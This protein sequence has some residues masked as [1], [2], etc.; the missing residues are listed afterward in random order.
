M[1]D[2]KKLNKKELVEL[3]IKSDN[4]YYN[5]GKPIFDDNE[6]DEIKDYLKLIDKKNDYFKRI[7]ADIPDDNKVKLPFF[8][9]SQDK[10]KDDDKTLQK[11]INKYNSPSSYIISEKLDGISCLIVY[12]NINSIFIYTRGNGIYGQNISHLKKI[13]SGIP[14]NIKDK[15]A[16]RGELIINKNN[17]GKISHKGANARNIVAGFVNSKNIDVEIA[18][19][20]EFVAY[21][22]LEPRTNIETALITA[23]KY[24]FNVVKNIKLDYL[25][26]SNLYELYKKWKEMSKYEIDGLV[27][28]HNIIYKLKSGENPKYS[29]AFKSLRMQEQIIVIVTDIEWNVSKDKYLKPIVKFNEIKLNGVKIK[30]ATGFNADYIVKNNIGIGSKLAIIRSGDVIP[31]IKEVITQSSKP[32]MPDIPYIWKGKDILLDS[33]KKNRE[34]DIKIYSNFM[35]S[36]NIKGIGEG[37]ITKL[38]DNSYDTLVKIINITKD[39]LL[40]ID[41]FKDKSATNIITS[42]NTIKNKNCLE[43]MNASNLF[44][45]GLGEKKLNLIIQKYPYICS[46]QEEA[47]KLKNAD[48]LMINGMGDITASLFISNLKSFYEFYN[49]L[50]IDIDIKT[51]TEPKI[52]TKIEKK[53]KDNIYVFSGIRDKNLEKIITSSGGIISSTVS[54]KTTLLIVKSYDEETVKVKNAKLF[55]IPIIIYDEFIK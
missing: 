46:N 16:V 40:L 19:Y 49:S 44:G 18:K 50:K 28:T 3:L 5:L 43:L 25:S 51:E 24:G 10:I 12:K 13:I 35:K 31:H 11:W 38:Y 48:L 20:I 55:N 21:D 1:I 22:V 8:L 6:Y 4:Q 26:I 27:I 36:L 47:L 34:Q 42:L 39:E 32:L 37:I 30:Q 53:Y 45:R 14:L 29:F 54:K 15:I 17:W 23:E 9:G 33:N 7:G 41:G 52:D 2:Y